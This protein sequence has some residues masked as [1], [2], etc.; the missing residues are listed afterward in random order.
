[1]AGNTVEILSSINKTVSFIATTLSQ[2]NKSAAAVSSLSKGD[3]G[4]KPSP[5]GG[6]TIGGLLGNTQNMGELLKT[7]ASLPK[8]VPSGEK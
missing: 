3:V 7:M 1:M 6:S 4:V 2:G 8:S 5:T